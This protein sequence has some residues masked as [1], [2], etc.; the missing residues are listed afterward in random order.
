MKK[1]IEELIA[2]GTVIT[3]GSWGTQLQE[4]GL[5]LNECPDSWNLTHPDKVEEVARSYVEAGSRVILT[6]TFRSNRIALEG[7]GLEDKVDEINKAGVGISRRATGSKAYVF[8]SIGPSG[9]MIMTGD[10]TDE[11]LYEVFKEQVEAIEDAGADGIVIETMSDLAEARAALKAAKETGLPVVVSMVFDSGKNKEFTMMGNSPE[12]IAQV[13]T[14]EGADVIGANCGQGIEG[15]TNI[16]KRLK[17]ST[18]LPIWIKPNAGL[19][20]LIE[21]RA[22]YQ[23]SA[24]EFAEYIPELLDSGADFVGGCCGTSPGFIKEI[25]KTIKN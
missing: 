9:K 3:D 12:E 1:I 2:S 25:S 21:G 7:F 17:V 19:P 13:L 10:V 11:Q 5:G 16:C 22:V 6:N 4:K 24:P 18:S 8:A 14:D 20:E 15:F 23:T